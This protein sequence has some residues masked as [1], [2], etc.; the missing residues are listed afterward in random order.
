MV[1]FTLFRLVLESAEWMI[2]SISAPTLFNLW[3]FFRVFFPLHGILVITRT[4]LQCNEIFI[5]DLQDGVEFK[6]FCNGNPVIF[7]GIFDW[8]L[9]FLFS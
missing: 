2:D 9:A 6:G 7:D 3:P 4:R 5:S 1:F 8:V